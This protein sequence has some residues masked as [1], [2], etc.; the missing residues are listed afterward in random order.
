MDALEKDAKERSERRKVREKEA[1]VIKEKGN[2]AFKDNDFEKALEFYNQVCIRQCDIDDEECF[3]VRP[4]RQNE[5]K[6][7]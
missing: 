3:K 5:N 4:H 2:Q 7:F 1:Q 6:V